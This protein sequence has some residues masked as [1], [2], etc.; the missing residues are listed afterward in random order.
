MV[1][2]WRAKP[3]LQPGESGGA[4][5]ERCH[6]GGVRQRPGWR[7]WLPKPTS[8]KTANL[9]RQ[10]SG[11]DGTSLLPAISALD[12]LPYLS[13]RDTHGNTK[14]STASPAA[15]PTE[16]CRGSHRHRR[17][18]THYTKRLLRT[19][20]VNNRVQAVLKGMRCGMVQ[21]WE[22]SPHGGDQVPSQASMGGA[23]ISRRDGCNHLH[24]E[25]SLANCETS[26]V[27]PRH[28]IPGGGWSEEG[29]AIKSVC[30]RRLNRCMRPFP[31]VTA[32]HARCSFHCRH[33]S[34]AR[35]RRSGDG[36]TSRR[37]TARDNTHRAIGLNGSWQP[38]RGWG[39]RRPGDC[40]ASNM[41]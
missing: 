10:P 13:C 39:K 25:P 17:N 30:W 15:C 26:G 14:C 1:L 11:G 19:L 2:S 28:G 35:R 6:S 4:G 8:S 24:Q 38:T 29:E 31:T 7:P 23:V 22:C 21:I 41:C 27:H 16:K 37:W 32:I 18:R 3:G 40:S 5:V 34:E 9:W 33:T 12:E 20:E 36:R